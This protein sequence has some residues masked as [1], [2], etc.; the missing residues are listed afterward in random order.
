M[1]YLYIKRFID[2]QIRIL[3]QPLV[4]DD[5]LRA[6]LAKNN[7]SAETLKAILNK[8]NARLKKHN[9]T[10][11]NRQVVHQIVQQIT[12]NEKEKLLKVNKALTKIDLMMQPV[13]LPD[14]H[15]VGSMEDRI[16]MVGEIVAEL[17]EAE[18][19]FALQNLVDE[20]GD[21]NQENGQDQASILDPSQ[22]TLD[23]EILDQENILVQDDEEKVETVL[24]KELDEK[25]RQAVNRELRQKVLMKE[26]SNDQ[27]KAQYRQLRD[28]L[29]EL[30][31]KIV[32]DTQ[33]LEYL[34]KLGAK[35]NFGHFS[36]QLGDSDGE[37]SEVEET[38]LDL[39][40]QIRRFKILVEKLAFAMK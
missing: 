25:Y 15:Q 23:Q 13:L 26:K 16:R 24:R 22:E 32:Y 8:A 36:E 37:E 18:Y 12:K 9:R 7:I 20:N 2:D 34:Q 31:E 38:S 6:F 1:S 30:N 28:D 11:F 19:L 5:E 33:K 39:A 29:I 17:P 3:N 27:L 35:L 10:R 14:F 40:T 4:V 21:E